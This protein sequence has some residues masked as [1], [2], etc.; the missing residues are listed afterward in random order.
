MGATPFHL[1]TGFLGSG[2]TTL[3]QRFLA[4]DATKAK[5]AV[6]QNEFAP[7]GVDGQEL[8]R[9][10]YSFEMLEVNNGSV[11]CVCLL[12]NFIGSLVKFLDEVK[13]EV[14]VLEASGLCD[15]IAVAEMLQSPGLAERLHL[16]H[17]WCIVDT[18]NFHKTGG[19]GPRAARQ[20]RV[21]DTV[22][23]NK[24]DLGAAN[25]PAIRA[26]LRE[27][28]PYAEVVTATH[29]EI[30]GV[31][32]LSPPGN[33]LPVAIRRRAENAGIEPEGRPDI[34]SV[35]FK[36]G[37]RLKPENLEAFLAVVSA[38][39][40]RL[41]GHLVMA[42]NGVMAVQGVCGRL[43]MQPSQE[44]LFLSELVVIGGHQDLGEISQLYAR[45]SQ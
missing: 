7:L 29:C 17:V 40:L 30:A 45:M 24:M 43:E 31:S 13:P 4:A 14:L 10:G 25:E 38:D 37:F 36:S 23:L 6:V 16:A 34:R 35:V 9:S 39:T 32:L 26:R 21:A 8:R 44:P 42:D 1:V 33:S 3:L 15:P 22:I 18:L 20:L 2:K 19:M 28:N 11:F 41:K 27:V 5:I 12:G